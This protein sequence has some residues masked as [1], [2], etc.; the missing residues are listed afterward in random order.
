MIMDKRTPV[1]SASEID[2]G[3]RLYL[4]YSHTF[5]KTEY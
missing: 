5:V 4:V 1:E 2:N 3:D